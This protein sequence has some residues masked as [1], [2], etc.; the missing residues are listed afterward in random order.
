MDD[1]VTAEYRAKNNYSADNS[2]GFY[3]CVMSR[4]QVR[5]IKRGRKAA[6][7]LNTRSRDRRQ[8]LTFE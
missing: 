1:N 4:R 7:K 2:G 5:D 8:C 3:R 6:R